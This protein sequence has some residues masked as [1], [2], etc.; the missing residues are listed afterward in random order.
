MENKVYNDSTAVKNKRKQYDSNYY[1]ENKSK[2]T[3][4][5]N[6]TKERRSEVARKYRESHKEERKSYLADNREATLRYAKKY[7]ARNKEAI[8]IRD[9]KYRA[10]VSSTDKY[11]ATKAHNSGLRRAR[12]LR[13]S[14]GN[15]KHDNYLINC[16]YAFARF[17]SSMT[18]VLQHVDHIIPLSKGGKHHPSNLQ[19]IPATENLS[20]GAK[21]L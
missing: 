8:A 15:T 7:R 11:K 21:L 16:I 13:A 4:Y 1:K 6:N 10:R 2:I 5:K 20:K 12:K 9:K 3:T 14:L 18:K 19:V 17:K